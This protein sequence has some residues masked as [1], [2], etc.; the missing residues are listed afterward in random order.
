MSCG[1]WQTKVGKRFD[2]GIGDIDERLRRRSGIGSGHVGHA[3]V[4]DPFFSKNRMVM[5][6]RARGFGTTSLIDGNVHE[7]ASLFH[8]PQHLARNELWCSCAGHQ[9]G[10]DEQIDIGQN[11]NETRLA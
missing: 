5:R 6:G 4:N 2:E 9:H 7:D 1:L 3:I 11:L 10:P 8:A